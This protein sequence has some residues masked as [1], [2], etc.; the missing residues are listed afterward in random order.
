MR[1][2]VII[3]C[4]LVVLA[5]CVGPAGNTPT[6]QTETLAEQTETPTKTEQTDSSTPPVQ[7]ETLTEQSGIP[8]ETEQT[9]SSTP[10]EQTETLTEQTETP[11]ETSTP[12]STPSPT[13]EPGPTGELSVHYINV[14]QAASTLLVGPTGE[15]ML[16][17]TG[18][19]RDDG[20]HVLSYLQRN[21]IDRIDYLVTS[22]SHADHIGGHA[23]VIDYF[24]TQKDG[25]GAIYDPGIAATT[26]TYRQYLDAVERH[27]VP[28]Y[29]TR[30]GD[31][32]P[33][34]GVE[35]R[36]LGPRESYLIGRARNENS[37]VLRVSLGTTSFL[38]PGDIERLGE[39]YL[40]DR[41][42]DGLGSTVL[43][44]AHHGSKTSSSGAFLDNVSPSVAVISSAYDSRFGHPHEA[45]IRR[46]AERSIPT[47]WTGTHGT[48]VIET[49]GRQVSVNTQREAP[50]DPLAIRN[51]PPI[52]L[53]SSDPV[54]ERRTFVSDGANPTPNPPP[55][56]SPPTT[57]AIT[58]G[59]RPVSLEVAAVH[60]DASGNDRENLNDEY[61]VFKNSGSEP[62]DLSGSTVA[63]V[64]NHRY[65]IPDGFRLAP[66][67]RVTLRTGQDS[68]TADTLY[69]G[70]RAPIWDNDGDT[71][72]VSDQHGNHVIE[73]KY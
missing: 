17:D 24:E 38:L 64:A 49:D 66:G 54:V 27:N 53:D 44:A 71:I 55:P 21:G 19:Y 16:I 36:V 72:I 9:D 29:E 63:D 37:I 58:D 6:E 65:R 11:T 1:V 60:A 8:T 30:V 45:V 35:T 73:H 42:G 23:A 26:L 5:G 12:T 50:T 31:S 62:I 48:I 33:F 15:T 70:S 46:L 20:E 13:P 4:L 40:R 32:I 22:H 59:G 25:I 41:F 34:D 56:P 52:A 57:T 69:W 18:D 51:T 43:S 14:G 7:T 61:V 67:W 2:A 68:N 3:C 47:Y 39:Y 10:T 28:L